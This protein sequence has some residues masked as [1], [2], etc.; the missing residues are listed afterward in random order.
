GGATGLATEYYKME[1]SMTIFD[2]HS[3]VPN[4]YRAFVRS[5]LHIADDDIRAFVDQA[6]EEESHLWPDFLLQV[7]P[8]YE[9]GPNVDE[10]A[11]QGRLHPKTAR[12][13]R[14]SAGAPFTLYRHQIA[15]LEKAHAG[16]SYINAP[17]GMIHKHARDEVRRLR[18]EVLR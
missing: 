10:L 3:A 18:G 11:Q 2:L 9:R 16:Q 17:C 8:S 1:A 13:F 7:S 6:L 12:I 14:T 5:F 4:N 15:A